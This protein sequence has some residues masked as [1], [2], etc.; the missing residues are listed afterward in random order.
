MAPY[1]PKVYKYVPA[2]KSKHARIEILCY[3]VVS[4]DFTINNHYYRELYSFL[5]IIYIQFLIILKSMSKHARNSRIQ[6][7]RTIQI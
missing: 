2:Y 1:R 5:L 3:D 6:K 4:E 7:R